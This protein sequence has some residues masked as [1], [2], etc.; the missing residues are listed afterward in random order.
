M[1]FSNFNGNYV[2]LLIILVLVYFAT[3]AFRNGF[4]VIL[5]DFIAFL[6]SLLLS[7]RVYKYLSEI[8]KTNFSLGGSVSN[9]LG[10]LISA[11]FLESVLA[12]IL[13]HV[14]HRLPK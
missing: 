11:I 1:N 14:V 3:E 5:A 9:A 8:L 10:F 7:L 6:G 13:G 4:W 12:Y 2:D